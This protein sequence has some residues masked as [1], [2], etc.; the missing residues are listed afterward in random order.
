MPVLRNL[1][2]HTHA[3]IHCSRSTYTVKHAPRPS[4]ES[5]RARFEF[6]CQWRC[7]NHQT[8]HSCPERVT[9]PKRLCFSHK[10][11]PHGDIHHARQTHTHTPR[12][13]S[14]DNEN[15]ERVEDDTHTL[16]DGG[17]YNQLSFHVVVV[18]RKLLLPL[19]LCCWLLSNSSLSLL[20]A[21]E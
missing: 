2:T 21:F 20:L 13:Y 6:Q 4:Q 7:P 16:V 1:Y 5:L 11:L 10:L 3:Y 19:S 9:Q 12:N 15:T 18:D 8:Y 14:V 17:G